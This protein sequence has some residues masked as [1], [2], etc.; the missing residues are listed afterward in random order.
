[1][2]HSNSRAEESVSALRGWLK[3]QAL[4]RRGTNAFPQGRPPQLASLM[5]GRSLATHE[6]L[7]DEELEIPFASEVVMGMGNKEGNL[8][9]NK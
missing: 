9:A 7:H 5:T 1:M 6:A 4:H 8:L 2:P 3:H